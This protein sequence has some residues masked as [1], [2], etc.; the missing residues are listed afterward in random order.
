LISFAD[1]SDPNWAIRVVCHFEE[2]LGDEKSGTA[3]TCSTDFSLPLE[4]TSRTTT[5]GDDTVKSLK[6]P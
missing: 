4:M 5:H 3:E 6:L 2:P 1:D